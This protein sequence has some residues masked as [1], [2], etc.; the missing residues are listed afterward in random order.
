MSALAFVLKSRGHLV[1]GSDVNDSAMVAKLRAADIPV[2]IGHA[3][4]NLNAHGELAEAVVFNSAIATENPERL[5]AIAHNVPLLHRAQILSYFVNSA[6][7]AVAVSGTHGKST[8]SAMVAHILANCGTNPTAILGAEYPPFRSNARI[9][10]PD[11]VVVEADES[12]GS[13]TLLNPTVAVVTNVEPEHLEN[14]ENSESEL[15]RAF[16]VFVRNVRARVAVVLNA[17]APELPQRLGVASQQLWT[18][19][20]ASEPVTQVGENELVAT[21]IQPAAP[22]MQFTLHYSQNESLQV[23]LGVPG[24]HNVSNALAALCAAQ[25]LGISI[26]AAAA[27]L[28]D[29]RGVG[30][31]F[32]FCG[33]AHGV[34]VY[35]DYAHHPTEVKTTL[36]AARDFLQQ[37]LTVIYQPHRYTRT[38]QM[39]RDFGPS[40]GAADK[41][42]ITELYSAFEE[43]IPGVSGQIVFDAVQACNA[44]KTVLFAR[45]LQE[46]RSLALEYTKP[47]DAIFT[48][49]AGNISSLPAA[50]VRELES[51]NG[52]KGKT[53]PQEPSWATVLTAHGRREEALSR[54]CT[55]RVGGPAS[56][57]VE[58][59]DEAAL[60]E[61]LKAV[62]ASG[63]RLQVL[64]A[65]SNLVPGDQPFEGVVLCLGSGFAYMRADGDRLITGGAT[66]LP[67]LTHYALDNGL[68][69]MEWACGIPGSVGGSIWGNA[70]ARG[71]NGR[72][73]ESRDCAADLESLVAYTRYGERKVL[74]RADIEFFYRKSSLGELIVTEA[75]FRLPCLSDEEVQRHRQ[76]VKDL[77]KKRRE[78][79]P[80]SAASAGCV[81]KNPK[82]E[83]CAGA[84]QLIEQLG[85]KGHRIGGAE[86][87]SVHGNFIVNVGNATGQDVRALIKYVEDVVFEKTGVR[88]EREVRLLGD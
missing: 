61:V 46:A 88:L 73:W 6:R 76:A 83:G 42:I 81:W 22:Y 39:G 72:E 40:F 75:T 67:K 57:W 27:T 35:D 18:Y 21:D 11:L 28:P 86:I 44:G 13:F 7:E 80:V 33:E 19:R 63:L 29:F 2:A 87:N 1:S 48:M 85:L 5:A 69:N 64:G 4:E 82:M 51:M 60:V 16:D 55:M 70:G 3:A 38:Q 62:K 53:D 15:W 74:E 30:R 52:A 77:L 56:W 54:H 34:K 41:I 23:K 32:Q 26:E 8:T 47:G 78:T 79:Q 68:G 17:D 71:F 59:N 31:R 20:I 14:Y 84:G 25:A 12:D 43:P 66:L 45:D 10:A 65:G 50:L 24:R 9:G 58:P 49:G 36:E 37:P